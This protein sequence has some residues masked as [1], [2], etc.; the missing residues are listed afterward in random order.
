MHDNWKVSYKKR[1]NSNWQ[2]VKNINNTLMEKKFVLLV[3]LLVLGIT[4]SSQ[5]Y[6]LDAEVYSGKNLILGSSN[7]DLT[8]G[9]IYG[10]RVKPT[11][12]LN[13]NSGIST[14]LDLSKSYVLG[15]KDYSVL[16]GCDNRNGVADSL[17]S[18]FLYG[19]ERVDMRI[20]INYLRRYGRIE[21]ELGVNIGLNIKN[22][23]RT[24]LVECGECG[25]KLD[26]VGDWEAWDIKPMN[27]GLSFGMSIGVLDQQ[28]LRINP[29]IDYQLFQEKGS[30]GIEFRELLVKLGIIYR[31]DIG[32]S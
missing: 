20:P 7:E 2:K 29:R 10:L 11:Y 32:E 9:F 17:N 1:S 26:Y 16:F 5:Q 3:A 22:G 8:G 24:H 14:G 25:D 30:T 13:Q 18:Y 27:L 12:W 23:I 31:P 15:L 28:R 6:S 19:V 4:G 21:L